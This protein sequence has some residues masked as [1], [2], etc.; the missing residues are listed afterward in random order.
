MS[1]DWK[2]FIFLFICGLSLGLVSAQNFNAE[3]RPK[4]NSPYSRF[5]LGDP[6]NQNFAAT[7]GMAG[8]SAA[9]HDPFHLNF[10][11]PASYAHLQATA[12]EIGMYAKYA[13]M[14]DDNT[15][16]GVWSGNLDYLALG[17]PLKNQV[18]EALDRRRTPWQFGMGIGL[19]PYRS[20]MMEK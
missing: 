14:Q 12:F 2:R 19:I 8:L 18:N 17:F 9:F 13:N 6:L 7:T 11:N 10:Q 3:I 20:V 5:G 16:E 15:T 4:D 1:I